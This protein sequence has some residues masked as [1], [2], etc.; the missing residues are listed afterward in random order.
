VARTSVVDLLERGAAV[1]VIVAVGLSCLLIGGVHPTSHAFLFGLAVVAAVMDVV[2]R[3]GRGQPL[4][5]PLLVLPLGVGAALTILSLVPLPR[6]LRA[7]LSS[8][9]VE[10]LDLLQPL[11]SDE[12]A[13]SL[14]PVLAFDPPDAALALVRLLFGLLVVV[15]VADR[16]RHRDGRSL[17]WRGVL[18]VAFVTAFATVFA[19][20]IGEARYA[21]VFGIP[22]NPNHRARVLGALGLLCL[23]RALTLRPRVEAA[24]FAVGGA[25]CALLVPVTA[26]RGGMVALVAG[27]IALAVATRRRDPDTS[28]QR[29]WRTG[30]LVAVVSVAVSS[31]ALVVGGEDVFVGMAEETLAHPERLKTFLWEPSL[32]VAVAHPWVG[33]GNNGFGVAFPAVL[34]PAELDATLTYTHAENGVL[35]TL[36]DHGLVGGFVVLFAVLV[37]VVAIARHLKTPAE[38]AAAPALVFLVVGD[39]FDFVLE[40]PVGIGI[41]AVALGFLSARLTGHRA[42]LVSLRPAVAAAALVVL[43]VVGAGAAVVGTAGWRVSIDDALRTTPV[44]DRPAALQRALAQHPS[45]ATYATLLAVEAR[46][47]RDPATALRW[48]N[49]ALVVWPA[50]R[51]AHLEAARA[52]AV[53]GRVPQA[54]LEYREA[55]RV[56]LDRKLVREVALR[57][58]D[59]ALRRRAL[60]Q[61]ESARDL[62]SLCE[63]LATEKRTVEARSCFADVLVL[64]DASPAHVRRAVA[65]AFEAGDLDVARAL[66]ARLVPEDGIPDGADAAL[67]A[68]LRA[69]IDGDERALQA[70]EAWLAV[71]RE[72]LPLLEWRL[73]TLRAHDRLDEA[74]ATVERMLAAARSLKQR[75]SFEMI[76][77]DLLCKRG[78][79][80]RALEQLDK[81]LARSPRDPAVLA[82]KALV[83]L[84]LDRVVA[85]RATLERL[86]A[87]A[88]ADQRI[89]VIEQRLQAP[90]LR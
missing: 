33:V 42:P 20:A 61:P 85:A 68:R 37:V 52:L 46:R 24:W 26:S 66:F 89:R 76:L 40:L 62:A 14:R 75:Q 70:S 65:L 12:V 86:R 32:R 48:A 6:A 47:R 18:A 87:V 30:A 27:A 73:A 50:F 8:A 58:T 81:T 15:V 2:A 72:P 54:M 19:Y 1:V 45:D 39:V 56:G 60:P 90:T 28:S 63:V 51:E 83:E 22:V 82:Q 25:L 17:L 59:A 78:E 53:S 23:G 55:A 3:R 10:R 79:Q 88:P 7:L 34:A 67:G 41:A 29:T 38:R 77:V 80:A 49:R 57:T 64:P 36:A 71:A 74:S 31:A 13:A 43:A 4:P 35:Q 9:S 11:L 21:D 5:I 84:E 44:A 16:A 69:A